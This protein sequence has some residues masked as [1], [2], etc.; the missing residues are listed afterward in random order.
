LNIRPATAGLDRR[1]TISILVLN[2][3]TGLDLLVHGPNHLAGWG[4]PAAPD[5]VL[6][7][8]TGF[9]P[10]TLQYNY[11][12]NTHFGQPSSLQT[13]GQPFLFA[14][15]ARYAVGPADAVQQLRGFMGAGGRGGGGGGG[16]AGGAGAPAAPS[17]QSLADD[18]ADRFVQRIPNPFD[19]I[20]DLKDSLSLT[21]DQVSH[22][23]GSSQVFHI[24]IDSLAN[25]IRAQLKN[26]GANIDATSMF[27]V[28]RKQNVAV[29]DVMRKAIEEA[30]GE[31]TTDQWAKVPDSIKAPRTGGGGGGGQ[32]GGNGGATG[33]AAT[34]TP[35][36]TGAPPA[37]G[38]GVRP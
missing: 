35:P 8:I 13:Y 20:L 5:P 32:R 25:S 3:L 15:S 6:L 17:A 29:R 23:Q 22:L 11:A 10:A 12:V 21:T 26:L 38:G 9:N 27:T 18:I 16:A 30:Q 7:T 2:T 24:R 19:Q 4:Q 37:A 34:S 36:S 33:G 28:M 14:L 31:L 1:L